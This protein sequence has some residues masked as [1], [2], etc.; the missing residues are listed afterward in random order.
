MENFF[1][2][3]MFYKGGMVPYP[4]IPTIPTLPT[5]YKKS[6][7]LILTEIILKSIEMFH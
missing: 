1:Q 3:I 5:A 6:P 2:F 7:A 4:M